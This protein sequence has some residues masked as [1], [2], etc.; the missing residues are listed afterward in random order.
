[1]NLDPQYLVL[2]SISTSVSKVIHV[3]NML[4][5]TQF[6]MGRGTEADVRVTDISVSRLHASIFKSPLGHFYLCDNDSKFGT[7][8]QIKSPLR[9]PKNEATW[10]QA[11][12]SLL[13]FQI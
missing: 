9:L 8:V 1:M 10:V 3:I 13:R 7:L 6:F 2:E 4:G 12:R 11:G 5:L